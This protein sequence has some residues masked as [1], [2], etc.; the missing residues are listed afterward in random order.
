MENLTAPSAL[1]ALSKKGKA[2][3]LKHGVTC[4]ISARARDE[5]ANFAEAHPD[6]PVYGV[7]VTENRDLSTQVARELGVAHQSPQV[8]VLHDGKVAWH[9]EHYDIT[10]G[11]LESHISGA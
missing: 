11:S 6:L 2:I 8:F 1:D 9:A 10:A 3:L 7:E 4:P 5:V